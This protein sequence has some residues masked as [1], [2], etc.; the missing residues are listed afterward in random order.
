MFD[1]L[2]QFIQEKYQTTSFIPLH[3][4]SF[5]GKEKEFVLDTIDSTFV[6]SI[7]NFVDQFEQ[8]LSQY[9]GSEKAIAIVNGTS[10]L[11]LTMV[12]AGIKPGDYVI[13]QALTFVA[14]CNAITYCGAEPILIDVDKHTLGLFA[15]A[16]P[17]SLL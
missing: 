12:M 14:T 4:P 10:A 6:S 11:H 17:F 15:I 8:D 9:T 7:G 16:F 2:V 3:E 5:I 13:T 1:Y